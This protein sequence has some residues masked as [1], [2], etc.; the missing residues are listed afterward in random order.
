MNQK[1]I[2]IF[3]AVI[4]LMSILP[5][6]FNTAPQQSST[7]ATI[8]S[9][10][11][12]FD[13]FSGA[14]VNHKFDS[15]ADA[16]D[17][18]P[19][20][21]TS[22]QYVDATRIYGSPLE[23]LVANAIQQYTVYNANV[24]KTFFADYSDDASW[25]ELHTISP[26]IISFS[27]FMSPTPYNGYQL[28]IRDNGIYNAVGT[29]LIFGPKDKVEDVIDVLSGSDEKSDDFDQILS[30]ADM[31]AEF[32]RVAT[33]SNFSSQYYIDFKKLDDINY[34]RTT[35]YLDLVDSTL[36]KLNDFESNSTERNVT[37]D[38]TTDGNITKVVV[39]GNFYTIVYEPLE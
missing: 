8:V 29:P 37:Y 21:V 13:A 7:D 28:L 30:Y 38:I 9:D 31:D 27:Y 22:A 17:M 23:P 2:A 19:K 4:M 32:Q 26:E 24:T 18:A 16:L 25:F 39:V 12:S 35:V 36:K 6:F 14:Q 34:S 1:L 33:D 3:L 20:G 5:L 11:Q 10:T 15:I